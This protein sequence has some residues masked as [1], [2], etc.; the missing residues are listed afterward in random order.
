VKRRRKREKVNGILKKEVME[1]MKKGKMNLA[2][3]RL[4]QT[5]TYKIYCASE[6]SD[7]G[8]NLT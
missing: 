4:N 2:F 3:K 5:A 1:Q 7:F 6:L 8:G